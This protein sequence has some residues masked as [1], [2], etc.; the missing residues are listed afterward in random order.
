MNKPL[1]T[2]KVFMRTKIRLNPGEE[3]IQE[4][5]RSKGTMTLTDIHHYTIVNE[6][7]EEVGKVVQ[8]DRIAWS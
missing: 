3:L 2:T 4:R 5:N 6:A 7:G 1:C 8:E